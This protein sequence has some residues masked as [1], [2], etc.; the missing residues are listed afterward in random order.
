MQA[1]ILFYWN[2]IEAGK[3]RKTNNNNNIIINMR[4]GC[5]KSA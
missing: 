4:L 3:M 2:D 1:H 5:E